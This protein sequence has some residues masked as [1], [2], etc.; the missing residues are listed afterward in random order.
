MITDREKWLMQKEIYSSSDFDNVI[1]LLNHKITDCSG[2]TIEQYLNRKVRSLFDNNG[3][4]I[5][6]NNNG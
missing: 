4:L 1:D 6:G 3:K 2:H 5:G